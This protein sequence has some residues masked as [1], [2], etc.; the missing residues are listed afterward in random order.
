MI[1]Y[2]ICLIVAGLLE[3]CWVITMERSDRF[4]RPAWAVLTMIILFVSLYLLSYV[5]NALPIGTAYAVWTGIGAIGT[6][7][8][9][10]IFYK[11]SVTYR[12]IFFAFLIIAGIVGLQLTMVMS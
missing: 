2:W 6:L 12:K 9:G 8:A 10:V 5:M 4:R 3:P 1:L 11:E 7:T